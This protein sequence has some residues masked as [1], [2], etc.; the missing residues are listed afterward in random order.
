MSRMSSFRADDSLPQLSARS[1]LNLLVGDRRALI[2][3]LSV[4]SICSGFTEAGILAIVAQVAAAL[5]LGSSHA[6]VS[7]GPVDTAASVSDLLAVAGGLGLIRLALQVPISFLP[8][9]IAADVQARLRR[10]L[11]YAFTSASWDMQ[12]RDR[13]G[14]LQEMMTSQVVQAT[15]G[16]MQTGTLVTSFFSFIVLVASA[17]AL[18][19]VGAAVVLTAAMLLFGVLRPLNV[20]GHR[21]A[22]VLSQA[23]IEYAGAVGEA[24]RVTEE[25]R[26]FGVAE[27]QRDRINRFVGAAHDAFFRTQLVARL[28]PNMYQSLMLLIIIGGLVALSAVSAGHVASLGAVVILLLRAGTY[29]QQLQSSYQLV[30]QALPFVE[31]LQIAELGYAASAPITG[32]RSLSRIRTIAFENVS[33]G[34]KPDQPVLSDVS[35]QVEG[36]EAIGVVGPSGAGKSTLVQ[37]L[38]QLRTPCDG[39]YLVNGMPAEEV[40]REDWHRLVA[41]LPQEPRLLHASVVD[42][43]RYFRDIDQDAVER[44]ARLARIHDDVMGWSHG[45]DT[46]VGPRADAISGGQQQRI[47][48][49][50]A[51]AAEPGVLVLD[52][53][54][55]ALDPRSEAL[56]QESLIALK[57]EV[58]LF[59]VAHRMSTL[60]MCD[61][62]MVIVDGRLQAFDTIGLLQRDNAY[63]RSA[64]TLASGGPA[65]VPIDA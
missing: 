5:V 64:S 1:Q 15:Q 57:G 33:F 4:C 51:L 55:S 58:T 56:I 37:L 18:N 44:A 36:G 9:R 25:T 26:V 27:A 39:V 6:H 21:R 10:D 22:R 46:I 11:F 8:A 63:Y 47:C 48:L 12:S 43:I 60:D 3:T 62:V 28:T 59:I 42:N 38:L 45:Y 29:G 35:F 50:R 53:P 54:T 13:E 34:Y 31:R 61:R 52:E 24:I 14:H 20:L 65:R 2:L 32:D 23:Q 41:Y 49:A 16:A 17:L 19:V 40:A 7:I 30:R